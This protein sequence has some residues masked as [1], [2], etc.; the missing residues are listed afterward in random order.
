MKACFQIFKAFS[1]YDG[2][3]P[4][5]LGSTQST[6]N[7]ITNKKGAFRHPLYDL[8]KQKNW[9]ILSFLTFFL[10]RVYNPPLNRGGFGGVFYKFTIFTFLLLLLALTAK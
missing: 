1:L 3:A 9:L 5:V 6:P 10:I 8:D 7:G 4:S 2:L